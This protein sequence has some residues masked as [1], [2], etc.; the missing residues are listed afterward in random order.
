M[1]LADVHIALTKNKSAD[2]TATSIEVEKTDYTAWEKSN[3]ICLLTMKKFIQEHLKNVLPADCTAKEMM[4]ALEAR[5]CISSNAKIG[6]LLQKLFNIKYDGAAGVR[7]Y[8]LRMVDLKT[9]L[10]ALNVSIPDA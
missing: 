1:E 9:K 6:T 2:I 4:A 8:V 3:R 5:N 7:D 10:Q